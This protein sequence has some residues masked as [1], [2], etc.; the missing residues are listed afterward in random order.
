MKGTEDF[1]LLKVEPVSNVKNEVRAQMAAIGHPVV[2]DKK[3]KAKTNPIR[4]LGLHLFSLEF[5]H[6]ESDQWVK[7][8]TPVPKEFMRLAKKRNN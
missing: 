1:T 4:R 7:V 6:P 8:H 2:G 3:Y 5:H